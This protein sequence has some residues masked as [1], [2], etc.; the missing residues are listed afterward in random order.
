MF[1]GLTD[2]EHSGLE[3]CQH[4]HLD[5]ERFEGLVAGL[6]ASYDVLSLDEL[7]ALLEQGRPLPAYPAVLT[8]DDGFASNYHL[9]Y[10][11]LKR[12]GLPATIY[13]ETEFVDEKLPI[14]V[15]RVDYAMQQAGR[16]RADLVSFKEK[17]KPLPQAEILAAVER[18]EAETGHRLGRADRDDVPAIYRALDWAQVREM[19]ASGLVTFGSHTHS[20]VILGR[21][22]PEVIRHELLESRRIIE[23]ETGSPCVHFCYPNGAPGGLFSDL[24]ADSEGAG[25]SLVAHDRGRAESGA[26][27]SVLASSA[28]DDQ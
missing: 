14:W 19:A 24:G 28:R 25:L 11:V 22:A 1:H 2:K 5:G 15:D 13:L 26:M 21:A 7:A 9:A 6:A 20:H 16:S 17:L 8:F 10:P 23:K 4:K 3:N 18:L 27:Q 12:F